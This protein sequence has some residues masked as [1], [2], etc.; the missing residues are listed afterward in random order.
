M[1]SVDGSTGFVSESVEAPFDVPND[2]VLIAPSV[3]G[4]RCDRD[5]CD[6]DQDWRHQAL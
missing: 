1:S 6:G 3:K 4:G 2:E 5:H